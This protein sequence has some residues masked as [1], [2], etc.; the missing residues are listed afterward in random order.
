MPVR[1]PQRPRQRMRP[2]PVGLHDA[3][4][5]HA[6]RPTQHERA[7]QARPA[8]RPRQ[9][10][11]QRQRQRRSLSAPAPG[12]PL[13]GSCRQQR[14]QWDSEFGRQ[15][16][17]QHGSVRA[18]CR[19]LRAVAEATRLVA[20][21]AAAGDRARFDA[22][23]CRRDEQA[24][25]WRRPGRAI[26]I[27]AGADVGASAGIHAQEAHDQFPRVHLDLDA[28]VEAWPQ[29]QVDVVPEH[30]GV[31]RRAVRRTIRPDLGSEARGVRMALDDL[32]ARRLRAA[33]QRV[34]QLAQPTRRR[35]HGAALAQLAAVDIAAPARGPAELAP[36][37]HHATRRHG[38]AVEALTRQSNVMH[39]AFDQR[40]LAGRCLGPQR[41]TLLGQ[42][43]QRAADRAA[44]RMARHRR[45]EQVSPRAPQHLPRHTQAE[46]CRRPAAGWSLSGHRGRGGHGAH[47]RD[48]HHGEA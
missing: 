30:R 23:R 14:R 40:G 2:Q 21:E 43:V 47:H 48:C 18:G 8:Q 41:R 11:R 17:Q 38:D 5:P 3:R 27:S 35:R 45:C 31:Q 1:R 26:G 15:V 9:R 22:G 19:R 10:Q 24:P 25:R 16:G 7:L 6:G 4:L 12:Q 39:L 34:R 33:H 28:Q 37:A 29:A 42:Q 46:P 32:Y 44:V 20:A 36:E 13:C